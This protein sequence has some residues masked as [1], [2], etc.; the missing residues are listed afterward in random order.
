MEML[1]P[2]PIQMVCWGPGNYGYFKKYVLCPNCGKE[3]I[4][5]EKSSDYRDYY[6]AMGFESQNLVE[7]SLEELTRGLEIEPEELGPD[8][9]ELTLYP[10]LENP[11]EDGE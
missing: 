4:V 7:T 2:T 10:H 5:E 6:R 1:K 9:E 8:I 3:I 11:E